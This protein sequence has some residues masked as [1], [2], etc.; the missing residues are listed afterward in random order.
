MA[1]KKSYQ[2]NPRK[3]A[4][5]IFQFPKRAAIVAKNGCLGSKMAAI[6]ARAGGDEMTI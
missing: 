1:M 5:S 2:Y 3:L 4:A 6:S